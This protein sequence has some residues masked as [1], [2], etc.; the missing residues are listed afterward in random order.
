MLT[1]TSWR[2]KQPALHNGDEERPPGS[3]QHSFRRHPLGGLLLALILASWASTSQ[4]APFSSY[5][6]Q[7]EPDLQSPVGIMDTCSEILSDSQTVVS[8]PL[9]V[10]CLK[11]MA[12]ILQDSEEK[13]NT[14]RAQVQG[15]GG[16]ISRGGHFVFRPRNG[17]RA[18]DFD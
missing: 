4:G 2:K 18:V 16:I 9:K 6:L 10:F 5:T 12:E 13:D 15:P 7:A 8:Y 14:K 3:H 1:H 11:I 17:R